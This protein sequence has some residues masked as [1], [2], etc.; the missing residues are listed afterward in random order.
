LP[1]FKNR[2]IISIRDFSREDVNHVLKTADL[3][4]PISR[5]KSDLLSDRILATLFFEPSTR[6]KLGFEAAMH[7]LGGE[8]IGFSQKEVASVAKGET[9]VDTVRTVESYADVILLRHPSEGAARV[10]AE[11]SRI[12]IINAGTGSEEHPTQALLDLYTIKREKRR[13]DGLKVALLGD[14]RYGRVAHSLAYALSLYDVKLYLVS[15]DILK[16]RKEVLDEVREK[17]DVAEAV[18]VSDVIEEVDVLYVTRIQRERFPDESEYMKVRGS[19]RVDVDLLRGAKPDLIVL[20]PL[21]R[22]DEIAPEVDS[23]SHA[24]YFEQVRYGLW[25]RMALLTLVLGAIE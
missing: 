6:T 21:P 1:A 18:D 23:T 3:M 25:V 12:P 7:R 14:L 9:L 5:G 19:Y 4:E 16:M 17:I 2:D 10:A 20:H 22:S 11:V 8:V 24:K 13:I 15:P